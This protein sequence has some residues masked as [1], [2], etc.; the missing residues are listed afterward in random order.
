MKS[1]NVS[2]IDGQSFQLKLAFM[3]H[4]FS[5]GFPFRCI[6]PKFCIK[7]LYNNCTLTV[8]NSK[9]LFSVIWIMEATSFSRP[10]WITSVIS[11]GLYDHGR[12]SSCL[13]CK[14]LITKLSNYFRILLARRVFFLLKLR[15][16][17]E[18]DLY[19]LS[20]KYVSHLRKSYSVNKL[21]I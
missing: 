2:L 14:F 5:N 13:K 17:I 20:K 16:W 1:L 4:T 7:R 9:L 6:W 11:F 12:S 15:Q 21:H 3:R 10:V 19:H 8:F 18:M